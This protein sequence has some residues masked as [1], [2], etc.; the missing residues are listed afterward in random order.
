[1]VGGVVFVV[2]VV[3]AVVEANFVVHRAGAAV[4]VCAGGNAFDKKYEEVAKHDDD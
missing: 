2:V 1:M 3:F 4:A